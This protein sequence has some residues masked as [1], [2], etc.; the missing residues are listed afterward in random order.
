LP[1]LL[2]LSFTFDFFYLATYGALFSLIVSRVNSSIHVKDNGETGRGVSRSSSSKKGKVG[3]LDIFGFESF[4]KNSFEQL[5]INYCNEALQQQFNLFVLKKEQEEYQREGIQWSY[6]TFPDNQ[7]VLDL[8]YKKGA[9]IL[10]IL[11][12]QCRAPGTTDKTFS[13]DLYKKCTGHARFQADFRQ[14]GSRL[15]GIFHYAGAVEYD[16]EGFV[17]K[18]R[19][20]VPREATELLQSSGNDFVKFLGEIISMG[21]VPVSPAAKDHRISSGSS[22][23]SVTSRSVPRQA[24]TVGSQF[25]QQLTELRQKI[26]STCPH[27][28]RCLKPNDLLI[29]DHFDPVIIADQ[30]RCAGVIEAVRVSRVGYPQR[31]THANFLKRYKTVA[32]KE[33]KQISKGSRSRL[34]PCDALVYAVAKRLQDLDPSLQSVESKENG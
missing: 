15:F 10:N 13:T 11:D 34:K 19:D 6:I 30:L 32:L 18:N 5:C 7:D 8:I 33:L 4:K 14:V 31:Y 2:Y 27:Y 23:C 29:P 16:T 21:S 24:L 1:L 28:V 20:E 17:E 9:G 3:V 25:A 22:V 12:D 26:D